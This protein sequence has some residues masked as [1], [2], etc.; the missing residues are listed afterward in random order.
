[1]A[2]FLQTVL[3][4]LS[5]GSVYALFALGYT[6]VFSILGMIN[7]AHGPVFALGAYLTYGLLGSRFGFNGILANAQLPFSLPFPLAVILSGVLCGLVGLGIEWGAFR[8]LRKAGSEPLLGVV[9]SLGVAVILVNLIQY[10]VGAEVYTLPSGIYGQIPAAINFGSTTSPL[11]IRTSQL[12]IFIVSVLLLITLT[13]W[14]SGTRMG[15]AMQAV[16]E[17]E[18][19]AKLLGINPDWFISLTFFIS[20]FLAAVAG[21]LVAASVSITGPQFGLSFGLK[22]L[23]VIVL[24]GLGSIPGTMLAGIFLGLV[25]SFVPSE[26]SGFRD[27]VGFSLLFLVLILRPQG[28]MGRKLVEKV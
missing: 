11:L 18:I 4:G 22:G 25:E 19:T 26:L 14:I 12:V 15:K 2:D 21:S 20:S 9:S 23:A 17:D 10:L 1:M 16:A 27:A 6:L 3:N 28:L 7:F 8:P 13:L 5:L 24:G